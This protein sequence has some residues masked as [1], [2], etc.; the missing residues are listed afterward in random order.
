MSIPSSVVACL[1]MAATLTG[2]TRAQEA[3]RPVSAS[4]RPIS[5]RFE[6]NG[7]VIEILCQG[8]AVVGRRGDVL[9]SEDHVTRE[10]ATLR[11]RDS[12]DIELAVV[13]LEP[14]IARFTPPVQRHVQ[15][16]GVVVQ[17]V[18]LAL[19]A[20]LDVETGLLVL[21]VEAGM[22]AEAAGLLVH[23]VVTHLQN[24]QVATQKVLEQVLTTSGADDPLDL[25]VRRRGGTLS[26]QVVPQTIDFSTVIRRNFELS[27]PNRQT[28]LTNLVFAT[29]ADGTFEVHPQI[30]S[31]NANTVTGV[32]V[33]SQGEL[34]RGAMVE[35]L[36]SEVDAT[37]DLTAEEQTVESRLEEIESQLARIE[38]LLERLNERR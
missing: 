5:I 24:G 27:I 14:D 32:V 34:V 37:I 21:D 17:P 2:P 18:D 15:R 1:L 38:A 25:T 13:D 12:E 4:D 36:A 19:A 3:E 8:E 28:L 20:Q 11:L 16:I 30:L 9:L 26:I 10:G 6:L 31:R 33:D 7:E 29:R 23:D 22:P 35:L